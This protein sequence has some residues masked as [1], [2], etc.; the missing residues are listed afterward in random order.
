MRVPT[1]TGRFA[2]REAVRSAPCH[3]GGDGVGRVGIVTACVCDAPRIEFRLESS[4]GETVPTHDG[5]ARNEQIQ[6]R[7]HEERNRKTYG[8]DHVYPIVGK[9]AR[10]R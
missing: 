8:C 1:R 5:A 4:V 3:P 7:C 2:V 6:R 9:N 10:L